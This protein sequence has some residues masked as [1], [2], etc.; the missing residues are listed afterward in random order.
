MILGDLRA[1][2]F[3]ERLAIDIRELEQ[4]V[5]G[6]GPRRSWDNCVSK[7]PRRT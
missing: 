1:F 7:R 6:D 5:I 2:K 4:F 3:D